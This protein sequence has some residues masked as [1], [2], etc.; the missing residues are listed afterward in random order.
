MVVKQ[1]LSVRHKKR[2]GFTRW[3]NNHS[4]IVQ[5]YFSK[6]IEDTDRSGLPGKADI[7]KFLEC[8]PDIQFEWTI[9]RNKVVNEKM[10]FGKR[11]NCFG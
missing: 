10:A 2:R 5:Q 11:K 6:W 1:H 8:H 7:L 4:V 3:S 9:V